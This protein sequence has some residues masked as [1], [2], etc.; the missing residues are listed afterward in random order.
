MLEKLNMKKNS[1]LITTK[2]VHNQVKKISQLMK[3]IIHHNLSSLGFFFLLKYFL[4]LNYVSIL[5]LL[6]ICTDIYSNKTMNFSEKGDLFYFYFAKQKKNF[7][8]LYKTM[9]NHSSHT[10]PIR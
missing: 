8:K 1:I 2:E 6:S 10:L 5:F 3:K 7:L 4:S 9:N